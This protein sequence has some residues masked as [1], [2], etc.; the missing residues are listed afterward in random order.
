M[1]SFSSTVVVVLQQLK[2]ED[3]Q[4]FIFHLGAARGELK[5]RFWSN[6]DN[7]KCKCNK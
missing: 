1:A 4:D 2:N 6:S 5:L 3:V 7:M